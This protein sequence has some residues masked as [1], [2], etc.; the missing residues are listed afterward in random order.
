[1]Q[2]VAP[3]T[4]VSAGDIALHFHADHMADLRKSGVTDETIRAAGVYSLRPRDLMHFF[5]LRRGVP[6]EIESALCF[7][8]QGG[9]FARIKLFPALGKMKYSQPPKTRA[10]LYV[11]FPVGERP[12][13][14]TEGEKKCLR[15]RQTGLNAVGI[16]G[17]WNWLSR[18]EPIDDLNL[19]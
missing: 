14:I 11:P 13:T 19:I 18:G 6:K 9:N 2:Y 7:P 15:A 8:Y 3:Y 16:G 1:M 12:I 17:V 10:R 4:L 5:S